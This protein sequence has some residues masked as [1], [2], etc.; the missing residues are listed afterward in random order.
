MLQALQ[1]SS[2][3]AVSGA[4]AFSDDA[5]ISGTLALGDLA[6]LNQ[7]STAALI[8]LMILTPSNASK[9]TI[10]HQHHPNDTDIASNASTSLSMHL[11]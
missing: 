10:M 7:A 11:T 5:T 8:W 3:L 1:L 6:M 2:T 9:I 4:A